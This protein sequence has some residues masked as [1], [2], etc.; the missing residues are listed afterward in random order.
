MLSSSKHL[1][2]YIYVFV[3]GF[4]C[5]ADGYIQVFILSDNF[6]LSFPASTLLCASAVSQVCYANMGN[7]LRSS[8]NH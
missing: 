3:Y 1:N 8:D 2:S 7:E 5:L 6:C 4:E